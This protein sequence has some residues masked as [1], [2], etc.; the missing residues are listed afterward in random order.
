LLAALDRLFPTCGLGLK[1]VRYAFA[2]IRPLPF[3]PGEKAAAVSRRHLLHDHAADG[4]RG[5]IS[6]I[7]GKLTTASKLARDCA[8]KI[9]VRIA[10]PAIDL[11]AAPSSDGIESAVK[12]WARQVSS[13]T[14]V[15]QE[16]AHAIAQWHGA[17]ALCVVR[18]AASDPVWREPIC[19]HSQHIMA[20]VAQALRYEKAVTLADALLRRVPVAMGACW[21]E[22]CSQQAGE[23]VGRAFGWSRKRIGEELERF[24]G[25]RIAFLHPNESSL[26]PQL[27]R[28]GS[29]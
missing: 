5:V 2:G 14:G 25:E 12:H 11:C 1:D 20:E 3:A 4:M 6:V 23:R 24:E 9:G 27:T 8:R 7:G 13:V 26:E 17:E 10:E 21:S 19:Q 18:L 29:R 16:T 28:T 15:S 22:E